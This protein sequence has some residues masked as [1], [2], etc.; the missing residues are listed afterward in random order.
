MQSV[1]YKKPPADTEL[2]HLYEQ[3]GVNFSANVKKTLQEVRTFHEKIVKDRERF[4]KAET[5]SLR[6]RIEDLDTTIRN[7]DDRRAAIMMILKSA[8]ALEEFYKLQARLLAKQQKISEIS[9]KI[10]KLIG[11]I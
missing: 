6:N 2:D 4:L 7:A 1:E 10:K 5:V 11:K 9:E 8:G 3:L